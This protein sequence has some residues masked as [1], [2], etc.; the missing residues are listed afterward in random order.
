[1]AQERQPVALT[2]FFLL[3]GTIGAVVLGILCGC[4]LL[5]PRGSIDDAENQDG[6]TNIER[7][8]HRIG[9]DTRGRGIGNAQGGEEER[10][11]I[12]DE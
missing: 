8:D 6:R 12:A 2:R 10:E 9:D 3:H 11:D 1:M 4:P 5:D 7:P